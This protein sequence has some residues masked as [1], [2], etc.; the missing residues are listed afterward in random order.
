MCYPIDRTALTRY[1]HPLMR[2]TSSFITVGG[3][4]HKKQVLVERRRIPPKCAKVDESGIID[5]PI[6]RKPGLCIT[7]NTGGM[8][9]ADISKMLRNGRFNPYLYTKDRK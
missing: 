4:Q 5:L 9:A 7:K 3:H 8:L 2:S 1:S 6:T